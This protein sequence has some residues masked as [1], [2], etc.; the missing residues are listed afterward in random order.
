MRSPGEKKKPLQ[1][2]AFWRFLFLFLE[3]QVQRLTAPTLLG[4]F[5]VEVVCFQG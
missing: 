1:G 2:A 5:G 3:Y 4:R